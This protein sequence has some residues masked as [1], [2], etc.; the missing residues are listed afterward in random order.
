MNDKNLLISEFIN[1]K[2]TF[3]SL[4]KHASLAIQLDKKE[5]N[6]I[7]FSVKLVVTYFKYGIPRR[8]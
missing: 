3:L 6:L 4:A 7:F 1:Y 5:I 2:Y 8:Y